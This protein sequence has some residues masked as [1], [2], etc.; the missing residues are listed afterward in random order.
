MLKIHF[1]ELE[2][3]EYGPSW[4]KFNYNPEWLKDPFVQKMI[5]DVD[6]STYIDG[7][8]IDSPVLGPIPPERLSGG[9]KTLIMIYEKPELIFDATSCGENCAKW[10]LEIGK[11]KDVTINLEYLMTFE[12]YAPFEIYNI[13]EERIITD[14]EDYFLTAVK[15]I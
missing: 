6:N 3:T 11:F 5:K 13:N 15:Y 1:G 9:V 10:L 12:S 4:F 7:L 8:V 2:N 14:P